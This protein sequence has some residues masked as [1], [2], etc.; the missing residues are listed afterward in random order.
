MFWS[1]V[2]AKLTTEEELKFRNWFFE[3][4]EISLFL[5]KTTLFQ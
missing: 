5:A 1:L 2:M 4:N 3:T